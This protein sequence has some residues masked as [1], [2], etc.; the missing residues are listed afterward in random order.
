MIESQIKENSSA[1]VPWRNTPLPKELKHLAASIVPTDARKFRYN[2]MGHAKFFAELFSKVLRYNVTKEKW[3][4]WAGHYW[5]EDRKETMLSSLVEY[6]AE[7]RHNQAAAIS[8][9]TEFGRRDQSFAMS[10]AEKL[11]SRG[12]METVTKLAKA[13]H[14]LATL[15]ADWNTKV[16]LLAVKN[17]VIELPTKD[18]PDHLVFRPGRQ[19]DNIS[20]FLPVEYYPEAKC[21]M[22][23]QFLLDI[24]PENDTRHFVHKALGY[25]L[26]G[27]IGEQAVF[28]CLGDG[29]NGKSVLLT[30]ISRIFGEY[31]DRLDLS[32]LDEANSKNIP[33]DI[34]ALAGKRFIV[35]AE[36]RQSGGRFNEAKLK[37]LTGE[38]EIRGR[39]LNR[40]FFNF[41]N[42]IK[43]WISMN[44]LPQI[45]DSSSGYW[46]RVRA[47][48]F[49]QKIED[50]KIIQ[51]YED[52]LR[53]ENP[54]ILNWLLKGCLLWRTEK[55]KPPP[56]MVATV[57]RYREISDTF[58]QFISDC[59]EF[60]PK[61][62][63]TVAALSEA[64]NEWC[65]QN[66]E[67]VFQPRTRVTYLEKNKCKQMRGAGGVRYWTGIRLTS[68][69]QES[70]NNLTAQVSPE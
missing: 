14:L 41:D 22:F 57:Q 68:S 62:K 49:N 59:C 47:I 13:S 67:R 11:Q 45:T 4:V 20:R 56:A 21:P 55:L 42:H 29:S 24:L 5:V 64:I 8:T 54:G 2:D 33:N 58:G 28:Y 53:V 3:Y 6:A 63:V 37:M 23:E 32:C 66:G 18:K 38:A 25:S 27:A 60:S 31:A 1:T 50:A 9:D 65:K 70:A 34:A 35:G 16:D 43:L 36:T 46:R 7:I 61:A 44:H 30:T 10:F 40:E 51:D 12:K 15:E 52:V 39:F 26:T 69:G 17:G 48:D 19:D